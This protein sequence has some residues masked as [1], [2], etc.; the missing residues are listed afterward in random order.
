MKN[1]LPML[2]VV[3]VWVGL[4]VTC[5][6]VCLRYTEMLS[7]WSMTPLLLRPDEARPDN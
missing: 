6:S 1:L 5:D 3:V 2:I 7:H 4:S